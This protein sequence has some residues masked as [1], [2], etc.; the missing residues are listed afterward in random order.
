M[1]IVKACFDESGKLADKDY[2]VFAGS[3]ATASEWE[4]LSERWLALLK[5]NGIAYLSMKEAFNFRGEFKGW[6]PRATE[7]DRLLVKLA[8]TAQPFIGFHLSSPMSTKQFS[9]LSAKEK[10]KLV[11]HQYLGFETGIRATAQKANSPEMK[12]QVYCDSSDEYS[13]QCLDLYIK[14]RSK[15]QD[16]R[17]RCIAITFAEDRYFPPL[18]LADMLSYCVRHTQEGS[19]P[20]P[21]ILSILRIF[22]QRGTDDSGGVI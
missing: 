3:V 22:K 12:I 7:R 15:N 16:L 9:A 18:Q 13:R 20:E 5:E 10:A 2:V 6:R 21:V 4:V 1:V 8:E 14:L 11:N 19:N 17:E